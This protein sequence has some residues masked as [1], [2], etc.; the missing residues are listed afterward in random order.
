MATVD[1]SGL[2]GKIRDK[3]IGGELEQLLKEAA[4]DVGIDVVRVTSGSQP[5]TTGRRTGSTRHDN[6]RAAD[7][8][9]VKDG[10]TA[11]FTDDNGGALVEAF[12]TAAAARGATGIGAGV[13][14]MGNR[15]IHVGFGTSP[16]DH[17]KLVWG[18]GGRSVNAPS[19]LRRA[20]KKGWDNPLSEGAFASSGALATGAA[21]TPGRFA[22]VARSGLQLRKGPGRDFDINRTLE[23]GTELTVLGFDGPARE[24]ARVDLH[25]DGLID[26]HVYAAFLQPVD[27]N[28]HVEEPGEE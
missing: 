20:A 23:N 28:E 13:G 22:V 3:P 27:N 11:T 7:L 5:G 9:L 24:W 12:V 26:G 21:D 16:R 6:R 19:W 15:T 4:G 1:Q 25:G 8:Q 14:Y 10:H 2:V 18:A 17:S